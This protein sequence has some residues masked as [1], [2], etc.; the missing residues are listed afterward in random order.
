VLNF[1]I[2]YGL[3]ETDDGDVHRSKV[4][5]FIICLDWFFLR[6]RVKCP[7]KKTDY[8]IAKPSQVNYH[9]NRPYAITK[10][11]GS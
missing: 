8:C 6:V 1:V 10:L 5:I 7:Q 3:G 11:R 4:R 2:A 9:F